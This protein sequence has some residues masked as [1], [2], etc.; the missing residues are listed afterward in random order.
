MKILEEKESDILKQILLK[1]RI[2]T[3]TEVPPEENALEVDCK[4]FFALRDI[5][6][7]K[8][9]QKAGKT[10]ILKVFIAALI[11]G[12]M[13]RIKSLLTKPRIL[14]FDTEQSRT[15]T[16]L[17]L[18]NVAQ[19]TGLESEMI[20]SQLALHALRRCDRCHL[21]PMLRVAIEVEKPSVVFIDGI[22]DFVDSFNDETESKLII[23]ELL[24]LSDEL[25]CAIICVLHTNKADDDHNMRGHLGTMMAQKAGT[26]LECKKEKDV[27]TVSCSDARHAEIPQWSI[28]FNEDGHI[29]DAD[30]QYQ[31]LQELRKFELE[32]KRKEASEKDKRERLDKC[33]K[34][35]HNYG[36]TISRKQL[37]E[38]LTNLLERERC[39]VSSYISQ[40][41]KDKILVEVSGMIQVSDCL[42]LP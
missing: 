24:V 8:A 30:E 41:L 38:N 40:W 6:A 17:I 42:T 13:F 11:K 35:L 37:T 27:I 9:K 29:V 39:T 10:T 7:V 19:M 28:M 23:K 26:V 34:V 22:V 5:H 14:F 18:E 21:L 3:D 12:S 2:R 15:D 31:R 4:G 36:G 16:K 33:L 1:T 20:D 32:Q 25:N